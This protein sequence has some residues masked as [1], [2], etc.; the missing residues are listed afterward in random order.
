MD[1]QKLLPVLRKSLGF[2]V[3][4]VVVFIYLCVAWGELIE[5]RSCWN[6][7]DRCRHLQERSR[8]FC[9]PFAPRVLS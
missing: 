4:S 5:E 7:L 9:N 6:A 3:R 2:Y 1:S 8:L